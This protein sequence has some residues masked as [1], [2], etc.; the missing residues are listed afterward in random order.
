MHA[1][2]IRMSVSVRGEC[3]SRSVGLYGLT[4]HFRVY[5]MSLLYCGSLLFRSVHFVPFVLSDLHTASPGWSSDGEGL[6]AATL[7]SVVMVL[8]HFESLGRCFTS[9]NVHHV[10]STV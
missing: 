5:K 7:V 2:A 6:W 4:A 10:A 9:Q 8:H 3:A 1:T